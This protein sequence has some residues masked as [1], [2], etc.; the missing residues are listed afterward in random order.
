[1]ARAAFESDVES[2][3][4]YT[5]GEADSAASH[6]NGRWRPSLPAGKCRDTI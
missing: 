4:R 5:D 6:G 2:D 3:D 1:M